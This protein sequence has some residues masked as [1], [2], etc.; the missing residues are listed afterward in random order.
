MV[1]FLLNVAYVLVLSVIGQL[2]CSGSYCI[3][4]RHI[5]RIMN[6]RL[7]VGML[8]RNFHLGFVGRGLII[9]LCS[10]TRVLAFVSSPISKPYHPRQDF[11]A[12]DVS[13]GAAF[14]D[15][16]ESKCEQEVRLVSTISISRQILTWLIFDSRKSYRPFE[17]H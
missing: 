10:S 15:R 8:R 12:R 9:N 13:V 11:L 5:S 3:K 16:C 14:D 17:N 7:T 6:R 1:A 4:K 2:K